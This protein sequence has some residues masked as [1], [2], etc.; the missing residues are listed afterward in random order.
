MSAA[1]DLADFDPEMTLLG[2][3]GE[4][5]HSNRVGERTRV[6]RQRSGSAKCGPRISPFLAMEPRARIG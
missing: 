6:W 4:A 3:C 5:R 2:E 1:A